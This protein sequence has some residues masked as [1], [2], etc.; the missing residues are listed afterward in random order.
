[1]LTFYL[2]LIE[3]HQYD[4]KFERVYTKYEKLM[5]AVTLEV[6]KNF[7]DAEE[8]LDDAFIIVAKKIADIREDNENSL[9]ALLCTIAKNSAID[10]LRRKK[11]HEKV[12]YMDSFV[13]TAI[14]DGITE[15]EED[16]AYY[17]L[18]HKIE[19]MDGIC[20]DVLVLHLVHGMSTGQISQ[21]LNMNINTVSSRIRRG[22]VQLK[23]FLAERGRSSEQD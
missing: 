16:E 18:V 1:M 19:E 17:D 21:M 23:K 11:R 8:A 3:D 13:Y 14:N 7:Y 4:S 5:F 22:K 6:T 2:S 9:K 12:V 20:R 10:C 15:M